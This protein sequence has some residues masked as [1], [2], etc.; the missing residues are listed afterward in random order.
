MQVKKYL[1]TN[2]QEAVKMIKEDLGSKAIIISTKKVK[3]GSGAFGLFGKPILEVTAARDETAR[4]ANPIKQTFKPIAKPNT[5]YRNEITAPPA[6]TPQRKAQGDTGGK[7]IRVIKEDIA[8]LKDLISDLRKG[9]RRETNDQATV[10]HLRY[11]ISELKG[12]IKNLVTQSDELREDDLHENL[13]AIY[14]QL[15]CNGVEDKFAKR[16]VTEVKKKIPRTKLD[17]F[18]FVKMYIA[19]MFMQVLN[20]DTAPLKKSSQWGPKI[21]TFL[22]PTGVGKTTT[23]AKIAGSQKIANPNLKIGMI[24]I[25][26][27]RIAAVQQLQEYARIIKV[28]VRVVND[29]QQL[30]QVLSDFK[31]KDLVLIDTAGRSQRDELQMSEL[32]ELLKDYS[33]FNNLLVLSATTK[34][35][36]LVEITKRFST[37]PLSGT[38]FTKLDEST[39]YGSIF[40]HAIRFKL[41]LEYLTTGQNVPDDIELA[42]RERLIDLL[43]NI[44]GELD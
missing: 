23:L 8:E 33:E 15:C 1:A 11:E 19:R 34:D 30:N 44:S 5:D 25:D 28:P 17:N 13:I 35:S 4:A 41:P 20:V 2:M 40:N 14:Q 29:H 37:V 24:T 21:L 32:R 36:D 16:L 31:D 9:V 6:Y 43:L 38:I 26:T 3:K 42:S 7:S 22:G 27:F 39:N 10:T 12:L 18:S